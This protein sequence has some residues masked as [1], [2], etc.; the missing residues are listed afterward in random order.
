MQNEDSGYYTESEDEEEAEENAC[1]SDDDEQNE[2]YSVEN[3][4]ETYLQTRAKK[5]PD[6]K[7]KKKKKQ[8]ELMEIDGEEI[9]VEK[10]KDPSQIDLIEKYNVVKDIMN[11]PANISIAQV[12][13]LDKD[14]QRLLRECMK[15][16]THQQLA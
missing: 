7:Q 9:R 16:K 13:Q 4:L 14:Q 3:F 1:D 8:F 10:F 15:R 12:L 2:V 11:L 6:V 5:Y